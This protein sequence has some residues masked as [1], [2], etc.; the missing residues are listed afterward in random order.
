MAPAVPFTQDSADSANG[1]ARERNRILSRAFPPQAAS[2]H[3]GNISG[4]IFI[5]CFMTIPLNFKHS[6]HICFTL[7]HWLQLDQLIRQQ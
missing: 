6:H 7:I 5:R 3:S 1:I 2:L 4:E